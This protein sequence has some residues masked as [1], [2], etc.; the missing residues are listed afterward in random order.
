MKSSKPKVALYDPYMDTLG[1][2]EQYM[3]SVLKTLEDEGYDVT[4]FWKEDLTKKIK[5]KFG[6]EFRNLHVDSSG[7]HGNK[8]SLSRWWHLGN[9]DLF[10][11]ITDG[12]Y[13]FSGAKKN[14][15]Y[16]MVP[17]R[18]LYELRGTN[19]LKFSGWKVIANSHFTSS[20][21][22]Q[23]GIKSNVHYPYLPDSLLHARKVKK[24]KIILNVGRFFKHL[25]KKNHDEV[26]YTFNR[27]QE[28]KAYKGYRLILAGGLRDEDKPYFKEIQKA[29][30]RNKNI[31][32]RP[33]VSRDE[34]ISLYE[35]A[36]FYWHF[37]GIGVNE[38]EH[39][40]QVEHL[41]ITPIEAMAAG[42][43]VYCFKAGGP[44]ELIEQG[45]NGFLFTS[46][47]ELVQMMKDI[48]PDQMK[49]IAEYAR[50]YAKAHFSQT[51]F[52]TEL[53]KIIHS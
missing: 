42:A 2:G 7:F 17:R 14:F 23:W 20:H 4:L 11:Y 33:N 31:E 16:A 9:F 52:K 21:L 12:S 38:R 24:E 36:E 45:K 41:G 3:L 25:H 18:E 27:L 43:V 15:L 1:G 32:L 35:H 40:E 50:N 6:Y 49:E 30:K 46:E 5:E 34:L 26:I 48:K 13:F 47:D 29:A 51:V 10:F 44:R 22:R 39:P 8:S 28:N 19:S 37:T 53:N